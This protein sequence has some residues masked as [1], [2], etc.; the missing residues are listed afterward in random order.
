MVVGGARN[1]LSFE[2]RNG[3]SVEFG[4]QR[5]R[6]EDIDV[7]TVY[8]LAGD[9]TGAEIRLGPCY[10]RAVDVAHHQFGA[11]LMKVFTKLITDMANTLH[12]DAEAGKIDA[13]ETKLDGGLETAKKT[14]YAVT[15]EGSPLLP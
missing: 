2:L 4:A 12:G 6:R 1:D 7:L 13:A 8:V 9:G 3:P 11:G 14:P 5:A 10:R 15:G